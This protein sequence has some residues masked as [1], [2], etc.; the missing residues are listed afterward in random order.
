VSKWY[1]CPRGHGV[2]LALLLAAAIHADILIGDKPCLWKK[3]ITKYSSYERRL[4]PKD[5]ADSRLIERKLK[6]DSTRVKAY[7][8]NSVYHNCPNRKACYLSAWKTDTIG[9]ERYW[10]E[11]PRARP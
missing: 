10:D 5:P 9:W 8:Y 6:W 1:T 11:C 4:D 7:G 3:P 2:A